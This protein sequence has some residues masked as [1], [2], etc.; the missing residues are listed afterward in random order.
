MMKQK[1]FSRMFFV[2][3]YLRDHLIQPAQVDLSDNSF[4]SLYIKEFSPKHV[5]DLFGMIVCEELEEILNSMCGKL[6]LERHRI[7]LNPWL[8]SN[9]TNQVWTYRLTTFAESFMDG[10]QDHF[11]NLMIRK[12]KKHGRSTEI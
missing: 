11:L 7:A 3:R 9:K 10:L 12:A 2:Y 8:H 4:V 6:I 1:S 5:E